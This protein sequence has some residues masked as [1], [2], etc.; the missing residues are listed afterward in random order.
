MIEALSITLHVYRKWRRYKLADTT[1]SE[2]IC[3]NRDFFNHEYVFSSSIFPWQQDRNI[4]YGILFNLHNS[5]FNSSPNH[6]VYLENTVR[7]DENTQSYFTMQSCIH[8]LI[9]FSW[10]VGY[11]ESYRFVLASKFRRKRES[12]YDS[13]LVQNLEFLGGQ[14]LM[15]RISQTSK[16]NQFLPLCAVHWLFS[17]TLIGEGSKQAIFSEQISGTSFT[18]PPFLHTGI[19]FLMSRKL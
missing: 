14:T 6:I 3:T 13:F 9:V 4:A 7:Q 16:S 10:Q 1:C 5:G 2:E 15:L 12:E 17:S 18:L 11:R 8:L 19:H